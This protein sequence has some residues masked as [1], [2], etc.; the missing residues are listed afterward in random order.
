MHISNTGKT[1]KQYKSAHKCN[2]R[3]WG[4]NDA[5]KMQTDAY[6][7]ERVI[8]MKLWSFILMHSVYDFRNHIKI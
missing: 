1:T 3:S 2:V 7:R 8:E 5:Y 4:A 6:E